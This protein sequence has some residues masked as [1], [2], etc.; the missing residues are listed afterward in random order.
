MRFELASVAAAL[1]K[2]PEGIGFSLLLAT[3]EPRELVNGSQRG[4]RA[5]YEAAGRSLLQ[6]GALGGQDNVPAL[7][8]A[9]D[10]ASASSNS[11]LVW[12]HGPQPVLIDG[13]ESLQ[14]R[15][16]RRRSSPRLVDVQTRPGPNRLAEKFD[17]VAAW[18]CAAR[19]GT[20]AEDLAELWSRWSNGGPILTML[21]LRLEGDQMHDVLPLSEAAGKQVERLWANEE[22][23]RLMA[24]RKV[25]QAVDL[26]A[27]HQI[28]TPVS[29]AVVLETKEQYARAGL[30]PAEAATV[31]AVPE[32][33]T[34]L[35]VIVGGGLLL[36]VRWR[37]RLV[38]SRAQTG[39]EVLE[40]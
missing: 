15:F 18:T 28:V 11:V 25:S 37:R 12:I 8:R 10:L 5:V 21:R 22:V 2:L 35:L 39:D 6:A 34:W 23:R 9:W 36:V 32:P 17:G 38:P 13:A 20:L 3:D 27:A 26:S 4:S 33:A 24:D 29:G 40:S 31:P 1:V 14:Q 19:S 30:Q 16:E 7:T